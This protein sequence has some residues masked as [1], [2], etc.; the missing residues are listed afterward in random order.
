M[1]PPAPIRGIYFD[2]WN[3]LAWTGHQPNPI[4]ALAS[5]YGLTASPDWRKTLERAMMTR[6]LCS[7]GEALDAI[8]S[9]TGRQP[10]GAWTRRD[11]VMT[12][13]SSSNTNRLFPDVTPVVKAL[14]GTYRLGLLS[15]TQSFDLDFLRR[16]GLEALLDEICLSCDC[17]FLKPQP[18]IFRLAA[19]M[20]GLPEEQILMVGDNPVDDL[21]GARR[22]G[23]RAILLDRSGSTSGVLAT[24]AE[25]PSALRE[26][27]IGLTCR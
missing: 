7:I 17:G 10:G 19:R 14:Q 15:N 9:I 1:N 13:G 3:T 21:D 22:A 16:D 25:L 4:I 8:E 11:L 2:L 26:P 6:R 20:M 24:L 12:W 23:M 18:E 5:A 27:T